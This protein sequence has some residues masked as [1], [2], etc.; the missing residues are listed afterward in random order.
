MSTFHGLEMAKQALFTQQSAL[1]TT[2]HNIANANTEGY[3]RQRVNFETTTPYPSVGRN[4]P[5]IPGQMG[6]GVEA[7]SVQ[8]IRNQFLDT[9]FRGENS[10]SG[11]WSTRT[12][13]FSRMEVLLNEP[14]ETGLNASMDQF[15]QSLN[16]LATNPDNSGARSVVVQR[17]QAL[18]ETFHYLS[19]SLDTI[20]GDL[21]QQLNNSVDS[22]NSILRQID[23]INVEVRK[24]ETNGLVTND[25][26]DRRDLL[27]DE[28]SNM[29][30]ISVQYDESSAG[31]KDIAQGVATI[32]V[33]DVVLVNG[34]DGGHSTVSINNGEANYNAVEK[35]VVTDANG[36]ATI[37]MPPAK[38]GSIAALIEAYGYFEGTEIKGDYSDIIATLDDMAY[39]FA[40]A[41]NE[42]H[43]SGFG[44]DG[45]TNRNFF[46]NLASSENAAK[47]IQV[48]ASIMENPSL[49]AASNDGISGDGGNATDLAD[50]FYDDLH[51]A[52]GEETSIKDFYQSVIGKLGVNASEANR[53]ADNTAIL[54]TQVQ[55][56]RLSV[57]SV[58][59]DE[60]MSN[61]VKFQHAY[62]AA[63]RSLTAYDELIDRVINNM[64]LVGR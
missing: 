28:L 20:R 3:T 10:L 15:W 24:L 4:R 13:A 16:G 30:E 36:T 9:Q 27:I 57:S 18:A 7:G 26:Y 51:F 47:L 35:L 53:M 39:Q 19:N 63:A 46:E 12:E 52:N 21:K 58:S 42:V 22:V 61:L 34:V 1:Y 56:Q 48:D 11:Y 43:Q 2:G 59:L 31:A 5:Q 8:R 6:T 33:G 38:E 62:N 23:D 60:E 25:L 37:D 50:V 54:L 40:A 14:S 55:N 49:V 44:L 41:F 29:M 32:K 45:N 17:G 64:G